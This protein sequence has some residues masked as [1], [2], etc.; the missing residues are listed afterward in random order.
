MEKLLIGFLGTGDYK[1][2]RYVLDGKE[3]PPTPL[4]VAAL[5]ALFPDHRPVLLTTRGA[6]EK[7]WGLVETSFRELKKPVPERVEIPSG[8]TE[9]EIWATIEQFVELVP[10]GASVVLDVT[11]GFR[12]QPLLV[13]AAMGLLT[14][15]E[16]ATAERV[17]YGAFDARGDDGRAPFFDFTALFELLAWSQALADFKR[18]GYAKPLRELLRESSGRAYRE[19]RDY[20][21]TGLVGLGDALGKI[22][23]ALS[24]LRPVEAH[25]A[26]RGLVRLSEQAEADLMAMPELRPLAGFLTEATARYRSLGEAEALFS[27]DGLPVL[28]RMIRLY[29]ELEQYPQAITLAREALVTLRTLDNCTDPLNREAREAAEKEINAAAKVLL[30]N[31]RPA[32]ED[33][34]PYAELWNALADLRNDVD[35]AGFRKSPRSAESV[36][37]Q[38]EK[39]CSRVADLLEKR[40]RG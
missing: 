16:H 35:H 36:R 38:A 3:A 28:G 27:W 14:E 11:H 1:H 13:F 39:L 40:G 8:K 31:G 29:L 34:V 24:L 12:T 6:Y 21:P 30:L 18:Y 5:S 2:V 10:K 37:K 7:N 25:Q 17:L 9:G 33:L 32:S 26:A 22:A 23:E 15:L 20:R 4:S 19:G